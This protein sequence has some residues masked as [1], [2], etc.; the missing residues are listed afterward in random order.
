MGVMLCEFDIT[1]KGCVELELRKI[2]D[3]AESSGSVSAQDGEE[4]LGEG[5]DGILRMVLLVVPD[6]AQLDLKIC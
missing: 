4:V 6:E 5:D 3:L 1:K 2:L